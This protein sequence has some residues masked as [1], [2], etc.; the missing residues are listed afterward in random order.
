MK[1]ECA[2][3]PDFG[4]STMKKNILLLGEARHVTACG[5]AETADFIIVTKLTKMDTPAKKEQLSLC[6]L[7]FFTL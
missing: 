2:I 6:K 4:M 7:Y 1:Q 3:C 5:L